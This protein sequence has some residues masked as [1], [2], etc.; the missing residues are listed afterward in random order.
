[1]LLDLRSDDILVNLKAFF[2]QNK[3]THYVIKPT[4]LTQSMRV[5]IVTQ[6]EAEILIQKLARAI[7]SDSSIDVGGWGLVLI[8][9]IILLWCKPAFL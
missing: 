5:S 6:T 9:E 7:Y 4:A 1:M 2:D 8:K 3:A